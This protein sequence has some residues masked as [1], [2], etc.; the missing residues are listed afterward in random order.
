MAEKFDRLNNTTNLACQ[1]ATGKTWDEWVKILNIAGAERWNH[2]EIVAFLSQKYKVSPWWRQ[3]VTNGFEKA[4][5]RRF[6]GQTQDED[7]QVG[8]TKTINYDPK[9]VWEKLFSR[10]GL[11]LWLGDTDGQNLKVGTKIKTKE[12]L[13]GEV[14]SFVPGQRIRLSWKPKNW[15]SYSTLQLTI[16][17]NT[18]SKTTSIRFHQERLKDHKMREEMRNH[19]REVITK[20]QEI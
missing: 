19:W 20:F 16:Y 17:P 11:R 18:S 12:G 13:E 14:K 7:F 1:K 5:G 4:I 8:V 10:E 2:R 3:M 9:S 6:E 15:K